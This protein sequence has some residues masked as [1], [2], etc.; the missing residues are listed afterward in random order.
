MRRLEHGDAFT[1][2]AANQSQ[3]I[4]ISTESARAG[5]NQTLNSSIHILNTHPEN[6]GENSK[7]PLQI[8]LEKVDKIKGYGPLFRLGAIAYQKSL[9]QEI[10]D[11]ETI[12]VN[13]AKV[14][15]AIDYF[16]LNGNR[17]E[18]LLAEVKGFMLSQN[19]FARELSKTCKDMNMSEYERSTVIIGAVHSRFLHGEIKEK[20]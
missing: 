19:Q 9:Q 12:E 13:A 16:F 18:N 14:I 7:K 3:R 2:E 20:V 8:Y 17:S 10:G 5:I 6:G 11:K 15:E 4:R 1:P